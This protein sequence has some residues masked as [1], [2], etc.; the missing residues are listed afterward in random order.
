M[1]L[2]NCARALRTAKRA[3]FE[4]QEIDIGRKDEFETRAESISPT[5]EDASFNP[6]RITLAQ[7][8][9]P[10]EIVVDSAHGYSVQ[11]ASSPLAG[12]PGGGP[13]AS[14]MQMEE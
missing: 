6:N 8:G 12:S 3:A 14:P 7:G 5:T 13:P 9:K 11:M 1:Q 10:L 4:R 2:W